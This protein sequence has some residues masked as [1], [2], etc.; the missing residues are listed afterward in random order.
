MFDN[1]TIIPLTIVLII[2]MGITLFQRSFWVTAF[3]FVTYCMY[4]GFIYFSESAK[5]VVIQFPVN[6]P[7]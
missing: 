1:P 7:I 4:I 2:L 5:E 6:N 3:L